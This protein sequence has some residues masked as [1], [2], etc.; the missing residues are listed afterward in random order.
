MPQARVFTD[1]KEL[2]LTDKADGLI[3]QRKKQ[4]ELRKNKSVVYG[5][6]HTKYWQ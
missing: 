1:G 3:S 6:R 2:A 5:H 4:P